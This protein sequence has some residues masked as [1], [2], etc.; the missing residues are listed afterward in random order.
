MATLLFLV[1]VLMT[2]YSKN[3]EGIYNLTLLAIIMLYR[4]TIINHPVYLSLWPAATLMLISIMLGIVFNDSINPGRYAF[5]SGEINFTAFTIIMFSLL[6]I[7]RGNEYLGFMG[8]IVAVGLT[9]SRAALI[10]SVV[11]II[12]TKLSHAKGKMRFTLYSLLILLIMSFM[13]TETNIFIK[14]NIYNTGVKRLL[15][16]N[17]N[18]LSGRIDLTMDYGEYLLSD[19]NYVLFGIPN[20]KLEHK[21][22]GKTNVVHNSY[23]FK[24]LRVGVLV[25][26]LIVYWGFR[27]LPNNVVIVVLLYSFS[28]HALLSPALFL[29]LS[30]YFKKNE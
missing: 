5:Y 14:S 18:S 19:I 27:I 23:I 25:T 24:S 8:F 7:H 16:L 10:V 12:L 6:L 4:N 3:Y 21:I 9:L 2:L 22:S 28:L 13:L 11:A 1:G 30:L 17:D 15:M 29:F 20:D 26:M